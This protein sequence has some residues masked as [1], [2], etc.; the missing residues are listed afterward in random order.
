MSLVTAL[1]GIRTVIEQAKTDW[2]AT[3]GNY[4]LQIEY[5]NRRELDLATLTDPYV[6]VDVVWHDGQQ[7]DLGSRPL[8]TDYGSLILASGVKEGGG[9]FELVRLME[10]FRPY[11]QLRDDIGVRTHAAALQKQVYRDGFCYQPM[12]IPFWTTAVSAS[13]P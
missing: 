6:M 8:V 5:D 12:L 11:L 9:T 1:Q 13:P 4:V 10:F 7:M 2:N 3:P